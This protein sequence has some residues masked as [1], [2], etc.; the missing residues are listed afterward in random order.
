MMG[1]ER[2]ERMGGSASFPA[3]LGRERRKRWVEQPP[4][5][6]GPSCALVR[7]PSPGAVSAPPSGGPVE[8]TAAFTTGRT[9]VLSQ[10]GHVLAVLPTAVCS[11]D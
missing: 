3:A 1:E 6:A 7:V 11:E 9:G 10:L 2:Q 5:D 8:R 4:V